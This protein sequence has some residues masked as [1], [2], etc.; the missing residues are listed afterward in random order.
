VYLSSLKSAAPRSV[1]CPATAGRRDPLAELL[2]LGNLILEDL[3][4]LEGDV[5]NACR[6]AKASVLVG[7]FINTATYIL[8]R[9]R[10]RILVAILRKRR[11]CERIEC[12]NAK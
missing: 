8:D 9:V 11:W 1:C 6:T 5:G 10:P 12:K 2:L 7:S 4:M 3:S